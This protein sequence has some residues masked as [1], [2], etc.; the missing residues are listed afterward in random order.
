MKFASKIIF[1]VR[2]PDG[3]G[4]AIFNSLIPPADSNLTKSE[5]TFELS[6]SNYGVNDQKASGDLINF[7]D[8]QGL[9]QVSI[10]LLPNYGPPIAACAV[11]EVLSAIASENLSGQPTITLPFI[12]GVLKF[13]GEM[14]NLPSSKQ[15]VAL[16]AAKIGA[17]T[18]FTSAV[19]AKV[20]TISSS[21]QLNCEPMACLVHMVRVLGMPTVLLIASNGQPQSRSTGNYELEA[22]CKMGQFLG[23]HL[24]LGFSK[25][26]LQYKQVEKPRA[27][28][29]PWRALYA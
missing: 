19:V 28:Q 20:V 22:L 5:S 1:L 17:T 18:D 9:P 29:E 14:M 21:L 11:R 7:V 6:L 3:F 26:G 27:Q 2:D 15:E 8:P 12:M 24:G 16:Y 23:D 10:V 13:N 4:P 25:D